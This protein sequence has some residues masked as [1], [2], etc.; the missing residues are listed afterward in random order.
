MEHQRILS[1]LS[2][3]NNSRVV[4]RKWNIVNDQSNENWDIGN[5]IIYNTEVIKSNLC[6]YNYAYILKR[7]SITINGHSQLIQVSVKNCAPFNKSIRKIGGRTIDDAQDLN[8]VTPISQ[9]TMLSNI[10][11]IRIKYWE[12]LMSME[13]MGSH[14]NQQLL[15]Y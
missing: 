1:S 8:L 13:R 4:T 12:K 5:D 15:C 11:S 9:T 6:D 10:S 2:K 14:E 7:V 3:A